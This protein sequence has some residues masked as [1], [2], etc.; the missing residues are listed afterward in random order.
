LYIHYI[1]E[2]QI[3]TKLSFRS[4]TIVL[5]SA[6]IAKVASQCY[7][8]KERNVAMHAILTRELLRTQRAETLTDL[9]KYNINKIEDMLLAAI[10]GIIVSLCFIVKLF[11]LIGNIISRLLSAYFKIL[12]KATNGLQFYQN[13]VEIAFYSLCLN[14]ADKELDKQT[15][16]VIGQPENVALGLSLSHNNSVDGVS[17]DSNIRSRIES[18][19]SS[20]SGLVATSVLHSTPVAYYWNY[21]TTFLMMASITSSL[22]LFTSPSIAADNLMSL[23]IITKQHAIASIAFFEM[24]WKFFDMIA[25]VI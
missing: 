8:E 9:L 16:L 23:I 19:M 12:S 15:A 20:P 4:L 7:S 3:T 25:H 13:R 1:E 24:L 18:L 17:F 21:I 2:P 14:L 6:Y 22:V 5:T 11:P 10:N